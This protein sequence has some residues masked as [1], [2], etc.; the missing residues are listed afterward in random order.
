MLAETFPSTAHR[1]TAL[2]AQQIAFRIA[3]MAGDMLGGTLSYP[4]RKCARFLTQSPSREIYDID[5]F[6]RLHFFDTPFWRAHPF[7]LPCFVAS[8]F[9]GCVSLYGA[10]TLEEVSVTI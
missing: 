5:A 2:T 4:S 3:Q 9:S 10:Y 7:A 6:C 8:V 1:I